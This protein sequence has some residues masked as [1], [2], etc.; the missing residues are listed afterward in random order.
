MIVLV[1]N[2]CLIFFPQAHDTSVR[3]MVW[4]HSG[5]WMVTGDHG[6]YVKYWQINMNNVKMYQAHKDA[7]RGI[8]FVHYA[9]CYY[10]LSW[11]M[12]ATSCN[13]VCLSDDGTTRKLATCRKS[14]IAPISVV[15]FFNLWTYWFY[16]V[17]RIRLILYL[18]IIRSCLLKL[19]QHSIVLFRLTLLFNS[20]RLN[21]KFIASQNLTLNNNM[22]CFID[23]NGT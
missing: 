6:G 1:Y 10:G 4:N 9:A 23:K 22:G 3:A 21:L 11:E 7:V 5:Q 13:T 12:V 20:N 8:R 19:L 15:Q 2:T 18:E 16:S 14:Q 17:C